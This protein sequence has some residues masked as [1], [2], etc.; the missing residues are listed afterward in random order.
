[1]YVAHIPVKTSGDDDAIVVDDR[2]LLDDEPPDD[3]ALTSLKM[4]S[5]LLTGE[6]PDM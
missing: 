1:M 6:L 4:T 3:I 2:A 5:L